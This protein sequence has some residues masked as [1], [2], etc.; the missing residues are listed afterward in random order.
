MLKIDNTQT[1]LHT[2]RFYITMSF[3][4][5]LGDC[6][7]F[8]D[9]KIDLLRL[10]PSELH[11]L[12]FPKENLKYIFRNTW[13]RETNGGET[14]LKNVTHENYFNLSNNQATTHCTVLFFSLMFRHF[15]F[16][17]IFPYFFFPS[18]SFSIISNAY[19]QKKL[20]FSVSRMWLVHTN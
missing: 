11:T 14:K 10:N 5:R 17:W 16:D 2:Y 9:D 8:N 3:C 7:K 19:L 6:N 12:H 4:Y 18:V 1:H 15:V 13:P 20:F